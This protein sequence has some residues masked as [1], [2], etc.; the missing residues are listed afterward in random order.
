MWYAVISTFTICAEEEM[1][2]VNIVDK[3]GT[4]IEMVS[5]ERIVG[6]HLSDIIPKDDVAIALGVIAKVLVTQQSETVEYELD[7]SVFSINIFP[8]GEERVI[9]SVSDITEKKRLERA[10]RATNQKLQLLSQITRHDILNNIMVAQGYLYFVIE[11]DILDEASLRYL[12]DASSAVTKIQEIVDFTRVYDNMGQ[13]PL[14]VRIEDIVSKLYGNI[15]CDCHDFEIYADPMI[16]KVF[17]NL[18]DNS[19]RH[20]Q[21]KNIFIKCEEIDQGLVIIWEDDG[22]GIPEA[23]KERI[24]NKG[25]G[26]NTGLGLFLCK[27]ILEITGISIKETGNKGARFEMIVPKDRYKRGQKPSC[28]FI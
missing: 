22:S 17:D 21:S 3:E 28:F 27:E 18:L 25:F 16:S 4:I 19:K 8:F 6:K 26:K 14:W 1:D 24:F 11:K 20:G 10:I 12:K 15:Q 5:N 23:D 7:G 9:I 13:D 2:I